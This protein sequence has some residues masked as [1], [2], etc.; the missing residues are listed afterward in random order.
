MKVLHWI[1][2]GR[3][4]LYR[5][6]LRPI[7]SLPAFTVSI[8]NLSM[9][10][11]GKSPLTA[12]LAKHAVAL[13]LKPLI[14]SR[15]YGRL[16]S[17]AILLQPGDKNPSSLIIGDEPAMI[18]ARVPESTFIVHKDR[19]KIASQEW[20]SFS[21]NI[22][23]LD[24]GFQ[25]WQV[26][27]DLD[28]VLIDATEKRTKLREPWEAIRRADIVVITRAKEVSQEE[29][30]LLKEGIEDILQHRKSNFPWKR[31]IAARPSILFAD[32]EDEQIVNGKTKNLAKEFLPRNSVVLL[33][34]IAKPSFFEKKVQTL[35]AKIIKHFAF[36][37]HYRLKTSDVKKINTFLEK[38]PDA[39]CLTT[40]KD[41][42]RWRELFSHFSQ[43]PSVFSV[44]MKFLPLL[45]ATNPEEILKRQVFDG[46]LH[47]LSH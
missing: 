16:S 5:K 3:S 47:G 44:E 34:G 19:G 29:L 13:G 45:G 6:G 14:L 40:E 43:E 7:V 38:N 9:G 41:F 42:Y 26:A 46:F 37:D 28:I 25:H 23:F 32:Y 39:L 20:H 2:E 18:R 21:C 36:A 8:G 35:G 22:V 15:G 27:R 1:A 11:T 24:D 33:S 10:G 17:N 4:F 31:K 12:L 30:A